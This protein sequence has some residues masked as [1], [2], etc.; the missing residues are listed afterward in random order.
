MDEDELLRMLDL[1]GVE[2]D[3]PPEDAPAAD[4]LAAPAAAGGMPTGATNLNSLE[5]DEWGLRRGR[6]LLHEHDSLEARGLD[7]HAMADFHAA[8]FDLDPQL[9]PDCAD[10]LKHQ[11][12]A[13]LLETP[14]YR[15]LHE[16]TA[17]NE[18]SA[19]LA[20]V[21]FAEQFAGLRDEHATKERAGWREERDGKTPEPVPADGDMEGEMAIVRAVG[22]ALDGAA[23]DVAELED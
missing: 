7:E 23:A 17:L 13:Q 19:A 11:F 16:S 18:A 20:A 9:L 5:V 8:A 1:D 12:L 21:R 3:L 6:D 15:G 4:P 10:R 14:E 2:P 22:V